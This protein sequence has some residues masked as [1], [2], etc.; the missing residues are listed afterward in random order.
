MSPIQSSKPPHKPIE[1]LPFDERA[2]ELPPM[3]DDVFDELVGDMKRRGFR[4]Q[5]PI[6]VHNGKIIDGVN[7][8]R[9]SVKAG[10]EPV[11]PAIRRQG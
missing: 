6:I 5:F 4:P 7:R 11:Y 10:V 8:A 1:L 3:P 9:A 2:L